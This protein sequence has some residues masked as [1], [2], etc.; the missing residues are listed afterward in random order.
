MAFSRACISRF[1]ASRTWRSSVNAVTSGASLSGTA[2]IRS[3]RPGHFNPGVHAGV[4][5]QHTVTIHTQRRDFGV[6]TDG[7]VARYVD[8]TVKAAAGPALKIS[9]DEEGLLE[10]IACR[11][12]NEVREHDKSLVVNR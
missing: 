7:A 2:R 5:S 9:A 4:Q 3:L 12:A 6:F 8:R 10:L 1:M 11:T